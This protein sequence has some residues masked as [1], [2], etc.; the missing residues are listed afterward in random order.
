[1]NSGMAEPRKKKVTNHHH[2]SILQVKE[3]CPFVLEL[4]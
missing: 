3:A 4:N 1:M 2:A